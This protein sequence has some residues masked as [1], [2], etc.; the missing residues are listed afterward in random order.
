MM[1]K[2]EAVEWDLVIF[3]DTICD[4]DGKIIEK[5]TDADNAAE[6][7]RSFQGRSLLVHT[8]VHVASRL[9]HPILHKQ[10]IETT[11]VEMGELTEEAILYYVT[12][13]SFWKGKA[14]GFAVQSTGCTMVKSVKGYF[15]AT[16]CR[17]YNNI[18]GLPL[19]SL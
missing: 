9:N 6:M 18:I 8:C 13:E 1:P 19:Y 15:I 17:C 11:E 14:G 5:P 4:L 7:L 3:A 16:N 12:N 2:L 10:F